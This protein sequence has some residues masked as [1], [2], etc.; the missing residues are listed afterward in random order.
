MSGMVAITLPSLMMLVITIL[1]GILL[2]VIILKILSFLI[3]PAIIAGAV[4]FLTKDVRM[5]GLAFLAVAILEI[6]VKS[7]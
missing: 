4:Y 7:K 5:A 1:I 6:I 2:I 3:P